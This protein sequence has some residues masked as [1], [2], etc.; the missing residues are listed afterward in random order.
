MPGNNLRPTK[1]YYLG[2]N[3]A[4]DL[5]Q[6]PCEY[7]TMKGNYEVSVTPSRPIRHL[8]I[9]QVTV[10]A[11][12]ETLTPLV[13]DLAGMEIAMGLIRPKLG[14]TSEHEW[15][16]SFTLPTCELKE[17]NWRLRLLLQ[18]EQKNNFQITYR[19]KSLNEGSRP[20]E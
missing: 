3:E 5:A 1:S 4:C 2:E 17:M 10:K 19:F 9:L 11:K 20:Q 13:A 18:D 7:R 14:K 16:G 15:K 6:G 8:E 12:N